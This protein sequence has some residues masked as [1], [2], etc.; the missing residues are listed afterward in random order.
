MGRNWCETERREVH[1]VKIGI[2]PVYIVVDPFL[3]AE[4]LVAI[5]ELG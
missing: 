4:K 5:G 1:T 2:R 3:M